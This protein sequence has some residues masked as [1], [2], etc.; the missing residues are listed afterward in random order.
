MLQ[1]AHVLLTFCLCGMLFED[2]NTFGIP[3]SE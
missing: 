3:F 1:S 2:E